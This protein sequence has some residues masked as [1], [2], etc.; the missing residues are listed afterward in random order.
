MA[1]AITIV[2]GNLYLTDKEILEEKSTRVV[3]LLSAKLK[4]YNFGTVYIRYNSTDG[5]KQ[6]QLQSNI[7]ERITQ[8]GETKNFACI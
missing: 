1:N 4:R 8:T 7:Q 3:D 6:S 2:S 5:E